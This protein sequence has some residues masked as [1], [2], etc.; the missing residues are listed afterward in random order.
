MNDGSVYRRWERIMGNEIENVPY[1]LI[2]AWANVGFKANPTVTA[3]ASIIFAIARTSHSICYAN[4]LQ[5]YRSLSFAVGLVSTGV[6]FANL[7]K[8]VFNKASQ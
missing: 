2:V 6:L 8:A 1:F 7:I 3:Y 4:A 5:P